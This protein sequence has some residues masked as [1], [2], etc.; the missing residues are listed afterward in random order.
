MNTV[1]VL[2]NALMFFIGLLL[3]SLTT[4]SLHAAP[5]LIVGDKSG[6]NT[7]RGPSGN[8]YATTAFSVGANQIIIARASGLQ[9]SNLILKL[10]ATDTANG[11]TGMIYCSVSMGNPLTLESHF[12]ASPYSY[13]GHQLF[14]TNVTGLYFTMHMYSMR[15][16]LTTSTDD[17]YVGDQK[18]QALTFRN[19]YCSTTAG[20]YLAVGGF[21]AYIDIE[22]Y[23]DATFN[24]DTT[25]A[26]SL[27]SDASY[28]YSITNLNP[29]GI[30]FSKYIY[31]TFNLSNVTLSSPTC[32]AAVLSGNSVQGDTVSLGEYN[33]R[34]VVDGVAGIPFAIN[35][36]NCYRVNNIEVKM[37]T[38]APAMSAALLGNS[39][40]TE[41]NAANGLGVEIKGKSN[42]H[43][44]EVVLHPNDTN[45]VYKAYGDTTDSSNGI[46]GNGA[47]GTAATQT[48]NF[49]A[50]LKQDNNQQIRGGDFKATA[51]F[52]ITYP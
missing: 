29:G 5:T 12:V 36:Q 17:F 13:N 4:G 33:P 51:V 22:F 2:P 10:G 27:L 43:F 40:T 6:S 9:P 23:N 31:Q 21:I 26:I 14:R 35:L 15:S 8:G 46:I 38:G 20:E 45:S 3:L 30:L 1:R 49:V 11:N 41:A 28:H 50:T 37:T 47:S 39:L 16:F 42:S 25:G 34:D 32:T 18:Q 24:P 48:L 19:N 44:A 7:Y 52:S